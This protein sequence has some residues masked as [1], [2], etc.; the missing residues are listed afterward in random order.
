MGNC[1]ASR[2]AA[3]GGVDGGDPV[4]VCRDRKRLIKAATERRF[5]LG[6]AHAS[7]AAALHSV[8]DALD[9][10][11]ARHTAP[12]PI[13]IS[14]SNRLHNQ[15]KNQNGSVPTSKHQT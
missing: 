1:A 4:T 3:G 11:V 7:Y 14:L 9:I 13:L 2:L 15:T 8:A 5:A 6:A 10:F 12:A